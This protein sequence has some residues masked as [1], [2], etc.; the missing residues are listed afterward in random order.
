MGEGR[1]HRGERGLQFFSCLRWGKVE[2]SGNTA[3]LANYTVIKRNVYWQI[4]PDI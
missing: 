1:A 4:A 3:H 2:K